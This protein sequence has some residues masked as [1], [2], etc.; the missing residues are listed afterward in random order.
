MMIVTIVGACSQFIKAA[1]VSRAVEKQNKDHDSKI[2]EIMVH[3]GPNSIERSY[4]FAP[5]TMQIYVP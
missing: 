4:L 5:R 2:K 3:T 1:S